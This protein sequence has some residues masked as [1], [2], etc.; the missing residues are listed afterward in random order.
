MYE[1]WLTLNNPVLPRKFRPKHID[2]EI[3]E[4]RVIRRDAALYRFQSE[5]KIMKNKATRQQEKY[6]NI[7]EEMISIIREK[8]LITSSESET[9]RW[10]L[11]RW[12]EECEREQQR[13]ASIW[14]KKE[15][16]L[17]N[18]AD[19]YGDSIFLKDTRNTTHATKEK[20]ADRVRN[21]RS[22]S[23]V[24]K[25]PFP[26][27]RPITRNFANRRNHNREKREEQANKY[28]HGDNT[29]RQVRLPKSINR[30]GKTYI[31][32][33]MNQSFLEERTFTDKGGGRRRCPTPDIEET[34]VKTIY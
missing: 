6:L 19:T 1:T 17:R 20:S 29:E 26:V 5:I 28:P 23:E 9:E 25:S 27:N 34:M 21:R 13:S 10:L 11:S 31:G 4:D 22:Y 3:E 15:E 18:Y 16:W 24:V 2:G 30:N 14:L 12:E 33:S 7:D 8:S 32:K